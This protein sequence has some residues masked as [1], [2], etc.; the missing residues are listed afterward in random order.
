MDSVKLRKNFL[1]VASG[2]GYHL[3]VVRGCDLRNIVASAV[4]ELVEKGTL[5]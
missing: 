4:T 5:F 2:T 3:V 1:P